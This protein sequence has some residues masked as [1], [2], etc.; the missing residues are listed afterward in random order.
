MRN[1]ERAKQIQSLSLKE[2]I[3]QDPRVTFST[4]YV[5]LELIG[6]DYYK[7]EPLDK[8]RYALMLADVMGH[9][10][11]AALYT[12]HLYSLWE[13]SR[14][15]LPNPTSFI[16]EINRKLCRLTRHDESY[17]TCI[18][19][20]LDIEKQ[21]IRFC[22]AGGPPVL[23]IRDNPEYEALTL[24]GLPLGLLE[25]STYDELGIELHKGDSLLLFTDAAVEVFD[26]NGNQL[27]TKGLL[28]I[29]R[30]IGYPGSSK[31]MER[32]EKELLKFSNQIR[33]NDDLT[34]LGIQFI[35]DSK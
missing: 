19:G 20:L 26:A 32:L 27:G 23:L 14:A 18:Y 12:M 7:V 29:V 35:G 3:I 15:L 10:I 24:P 31:K 6:G 13:E 8:D 9:G 11:A 4:Y 21:S 33:L 5:P 30:E 16:E 25:E 1:L 17:A 28:N 34:I 2:E 22:S